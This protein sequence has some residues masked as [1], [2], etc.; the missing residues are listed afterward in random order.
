MRLCGLRDSVMGISA[1]MV[2]ALKL[3]LPLIAESIV[4]PSGATC[5]LYTVLC[6]CLGV[7]YGI[8]FFCLVLF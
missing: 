3:S 4:Y 7:A 5:C 8:F 1:N 2:A 6:I